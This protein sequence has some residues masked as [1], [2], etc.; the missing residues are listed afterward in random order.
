MKYIKKF[1]T[2]ENIN[3]DPKIGDYVIIKTTHKKE[4]YNFITSNIGKIVN[5]NLPLDEVTVKYN[6]VPP[7][8]KQHFI[9]NTG[10]YGDQYYV[11]M[12]PISYIKY[13]SKNEEELQLKL[14]TQKYNL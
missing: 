5:A 7:E 2:H 11:R 1:E 8:L 10:R 12:F 3:K 14:D 13:I 4:I 6:N 9:L